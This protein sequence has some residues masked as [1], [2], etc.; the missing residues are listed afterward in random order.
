MI[1]CLTNAEADKRFIVCWHPVSCRQH[2]GTVESGAL[3][4]FTRSAAH[5]TYRTTTQ[6]ERGVQQRRRERGCR[7]NVCLTEF[8]LQLMRTIREGALH[9]S[10]GPLVRVAVLLTTLQLARPLDAQNPRVLS[11]AD[12]D[13]AARF[14]GGNL[15]GLVVGGNV[16][17]RWL[18][19]GRF[20][21][22]SITSVG[23]DLMIVDPVRRSRT[24]ATAADTA[25]SQATAAG[26]VSTRGGGGPRTGGAAGV[27]SPDGKRSAFIRE[28]NLW[29][30]T[31][32]PGRS[33]S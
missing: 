26:G 12:Y 9:R 21:Y 15:A 3:V 29:C 27:V 17:A 2:C 20:W 28:W 30:G 7:G 18:S 14:L 25:G 31:S 5:A 24:K 19:D 13:R 32:P 33:V 23:S 4:N 11:T 8:C 22:T 16:Q 1:G 10:F 6:H